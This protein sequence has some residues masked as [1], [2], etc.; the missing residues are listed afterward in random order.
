MTKLP[1]IY[2]TLLFS[3]ARSN[4]YMLKIKCIIHLRE[5]QTL[6]LSYLTR[7]CMACNGIFQLAKCGFLQDCKDVKSTC[8][9]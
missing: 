9:Y 6:G 8:R 3:P 4:L 1:S 5:V 2:V 7:L